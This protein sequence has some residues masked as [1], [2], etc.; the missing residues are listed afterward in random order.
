MTFELFEEI[1]RAYS[2]GK[3]LACR[4]ALKK[5]GFNDA[6]AGALRTAH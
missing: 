3:L 5:T 2:L 6:L 1:S 4:V